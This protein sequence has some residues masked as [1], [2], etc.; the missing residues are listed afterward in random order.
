MMQAYQETKKALEGILERVEPNRSNE[1]VQ[2]F[3][4]DWLYKLRILMAV[5]SGS[6]PSLPFLHVFSSVGL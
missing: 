2:N 6:V 5:I 3:L 1:I 4:L